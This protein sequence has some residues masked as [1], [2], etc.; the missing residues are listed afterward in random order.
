MKLGHQ[1]ISRVGSYVNSLLSCCDRVILTGYLPFWSA[2]YVNGWIGGELRIRH[3][4]F[5]PRMKRL[6]DQLVDFAK[7]KAKRCGAPYR[8][9][10]GKCRKESLIDAID[11]ERKHP[12]G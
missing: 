11:R 7:A 8:V 4:D 10:Q 5:L 12:K 2:G 6:S 3:K 9:L 1:F